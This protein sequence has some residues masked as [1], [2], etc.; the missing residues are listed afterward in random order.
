ML[1]RLLS[2]IQ[3]FGNYEKLSDFI[4]ELTAARTPRE[5]CRKVFRRLKESYGVDNIRRPLLLLAVSEKGLS[6]EEIKTDGMASQYLWLRLRGELASWMTE[7]LGLYRISDPEMSDVVIEE[8][9]GE[10]AEAFARRTIIYKIAED[11]S[12]AE[13]SLADFNMRSGHFA[14]NDRYLHLEDRIS[15][16][17]SAT[18]K[19]LRI[20][21]TGRSFSRCCS[22]IIRNFSNA[23][24]R[25]LPTI[26]RD[27]IS[28]N[29][30]KWI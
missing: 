23:L 6:E 9:G 12:P 14:Y 22:A 7:E 19:A 11:L 29:I 26:F 1:V 17:N 20:F 10:E 5:F 4:K 16:S 18:G 13:L 3:E 21:P 28:R 25:L 15:L 8:L 2:E 27:S 24:C 30:S